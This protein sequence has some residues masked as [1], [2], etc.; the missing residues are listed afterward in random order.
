MSA[1]Q[2]AQT[3]RVLQR[4]CLGQLQLEILLQELGE[5]L[6]DL[7]GFCLRSGEPEQKEATNCLLI[8]SARHVEAKL[9]PRW[10]VN[11][12]ATPPG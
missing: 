2:G 9:A 7:L 11:N 3:T 8:G 1:W 12:D 10:R 4:L 6:L 5:A